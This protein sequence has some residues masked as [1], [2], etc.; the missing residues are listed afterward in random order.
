M[1]GN[2]LVVSAHA[3]DFCTRAGGTIIRYL[4]MGWNVTVMCMTFG[5]RGES[6][7]YWRVNPTSTVEECKRSRKQEAQNVADFLGIT[8]E[9]YDY[10]DYP[11]VFTADA[12]RNI[13][14]KILTLRPEIILTHFNRDPLNN[15]HAATSGAVVQALASAAQLGALPN[16]PAHYFPNVYF[17]ESTVPHS[18]FNEFKMDTYIDITQTFERK[19]EAI[20][21]FTAQPQLGNYYRHFAE[22]R[23]FQATDW[24]KRPIKYAEGFFRFLPYVGEEFPLMLRK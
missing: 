7:N 5:E 4:D 10:N 2:I 8:I 6:G 18:E 17:F 19:M 9:F 1:A 24:A 13:T 15:D 11:L 20:R 12:V 14:K 22:H 23:G 21:L 3:A 16:T